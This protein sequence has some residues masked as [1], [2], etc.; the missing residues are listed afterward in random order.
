MKFRRAA[1]ADLGAILA[2]QEANL[3]E[4][5]SGEQRADGFLLKDE[6]R[7]RFDAAVA[8]IAKSNARSL[9][10]HVDGLGMTL[11]GDFTHAGKNYWIIAFGVPPEAVSCAV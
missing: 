5:L 10:A 6:L 11:A 1:P 2:L 9:A 7:G 4:N 3:H 8:F